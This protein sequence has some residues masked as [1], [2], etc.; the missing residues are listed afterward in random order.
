MRYELA[1]LEWAAI[2][3][4]LPNKPRGAPL[5]NDRSADDPGTNQPGASW[6]FVARADIQGG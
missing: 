3:P 2:K 6:L 5:V 4:M 1:D